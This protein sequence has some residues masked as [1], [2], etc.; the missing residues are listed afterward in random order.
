MAEKM[1]K[2][3]TVQPKNSYEEAYFKAVRQTVVGA[4]DESIGFDEDV[5]AAGT[6]VLEIA[7]AMQT[8]RANRAEKGD[9]ALERAVAD[10]D[11]RLGKASLQA[12]AMLESAPNSPAAEEQLPSTAE[13]GL[14][15]VIPLQRPA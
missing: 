10:T 8:A 2:F 11:Q 6:D 3:G 12:T 13:E 9:F 4:G 14:A 15:E 1:N 5:T 7:K